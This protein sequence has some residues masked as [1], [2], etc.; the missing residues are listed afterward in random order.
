VGL[1]REKIGPA[2]PLGS[3]FSR[4]FH[5]VITLPRVGPPYYPPAPKAPHEPE[6]SHDGEGPRA[7]REPDESNDGEDLHH[8]PP[9]R[10]DPRLRR[11]VAQGDVALSCHGATTGRSSSELS[12]PSLIGRGT[13]TV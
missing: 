11:T 7:L 5:P 12:T 8:V 1:C 6:E 10:V 13:R 9:S 4:L 2:P 3:A